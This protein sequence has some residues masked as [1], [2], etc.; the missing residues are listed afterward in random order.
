MDGWTGG[1]LGDENPH[2]NSG[3][4]SVF[5]DPDATHRFADVA[6]R[7]TLDWAWDYLLNKYY[8]NPEKQIP[9]ISPPLSVYAVS[10]E[11]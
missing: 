7:E 4:I 1:R 3:L 10:C 11:K 8:T 9:K 5:V 2:I 6:A